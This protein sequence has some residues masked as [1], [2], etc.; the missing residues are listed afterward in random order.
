MIIET[1][2]TSTPYGEKIRTFLQQ[3]LEIVPQEKS[4]LLDIITDIIVGT[5]KYRSAPLPKPESLVAIRSVIRTSMNKNEPIPVLIP[6]GGRKAIANQSLDVAEVMSLK[7]LK[8]IN[9]KIIKFYTPGLQINLA[10]EDTGAQW[11]Y[12]KE[13]DT[14][15]E[16]ELYSS[17]LVDLIDIMELNFLKGIRESTLMDESEYFMLSDKFS[18]VIFNY[19]IMSNQFPE[20]IGQFD[21]ELNDI[22]WTGEIPMRQREYY[23]GRYKTLKPGLSDEDY[24]RMM[25]DYFGGALARYKLNGKAAPKGNNGE[26]SSKDYIKILFVPP[27]PGAPEAITST[28]V[29]YRPVTKNYTEYCMLLGEAKDI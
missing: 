27:V 5:T 6:W 8:V 25:A 7:L 4:N 29:Y 23:I 10:I 28:N 16:I 19:I 21:K 1:P 9:E 2:N 17:K 14:R 20:K 22:G 13:P 24:Y 26:L 12:R 15:Y 18:K 11:I 3:E